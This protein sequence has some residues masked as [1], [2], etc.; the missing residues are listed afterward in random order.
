MK[1]KERVMHLLNHQTPDRMPCF[2]ANAA[3]TYD[4]MEAVQ[5]FWP[6]GHEKV[7][8]MARLALAAHTVLGLDAIRVP[9]C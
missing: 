6:E 9:F 1:A 7:G 4:Q 5:A 8:T 2:A 3:V